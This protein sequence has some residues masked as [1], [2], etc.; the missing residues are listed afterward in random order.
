MLAS[1]RAYFCTWCGS[2][3]RHG[4]C[5]DNVCRMR[6]RCNCVDL[7]VCVS[8]LRLPY[9]LSV[10]FCA[11]GTP[12]VGGRHLFCVRIAAQDI[13]T[14]DPRQMIVVS[15][16]PLIRR[17]TST[18]GLRMYVQHARATGR[19]SRPG[20]RARRR[21]SVS[22]SRACAKDRV[23]FIDV[24]VRMSVCGCVGA[25]RCRSSSTRSPP[26]ASRS[27]ARSASSRARRS[28]S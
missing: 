12:P 19:L 4:D 26:S 7:G 28:A 16:N 27:A 9:V 24:C 25:R 2:V 13:P 3:S 14:P 10:F 15:H 21:S 6:G 11:L 22:R 23:A 1:G 5:G 20:W 8:S 17:C 18:A